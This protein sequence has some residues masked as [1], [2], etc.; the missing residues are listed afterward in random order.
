VEAVTF[1]KSSYYT[2]EEKNIIA[3]NSRNLVTALKKHI[4]VAE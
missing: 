1:R 4:S 3:E 2:P